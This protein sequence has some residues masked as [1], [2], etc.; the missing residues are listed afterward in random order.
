MYILAVDDEQLP[1]DTLLNELK[2]VFPNA[3]IHGEKKSISAVEWLK[4]LKQRGESLQYAFLDI[5]MKGLNG[6]ELA[7]IIKTLFPNA[8]LFF[9]TAYSEY[10]FD[11]FG[12][13]AKGYLMKPITAK[14]I[15]KNLDEMVYDWRA[16]PSEFTRDIRIQTFGNFEVF[17]DGKPLVFE[18]EKAKELFAYLVDRHGASATTEQIALVLWEKAKYDKRLKNMTTTIVSSLKNSLKSVGLEK[19]LI[20]SWN[21]LAL[22]ISKV[23]CDSYDYEKGDVIAVNSFRGEYMANYSWAEFTTG[24]YIFK[25]K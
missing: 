14:S 4:E 3:V 20:K 11:A 18:R 24:K 19:L 22:D 6:L 16:E 2:I 23:K 15:E 8:A 13:Y 17:V 25:N 10:A 5:D 7:K 1:L 12:L 9:C 21:H